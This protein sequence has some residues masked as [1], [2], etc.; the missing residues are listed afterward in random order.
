MTDAREELQAALGVTYAIDR[1]LGGGGMSRAFI[2]TER[3]LGRQVVIKVLP[4]DTAGAVSVERFKREIAFAARL[5]QANIVPLLSAGEMGGVPYFTMPYIAGQSLRARLAAEGPL[6]IADAIVI[7]TEVARALAYAH[8]A[9]VVHRDIKPDT[10]L[11]SAGTAMVTDFGVAKAISTTTTA[12]GADL[13]GTGVALGT[14]AYMSPEQAS[15]DPLADH[16]AR[17]VRS[18]RFATSRASR[19]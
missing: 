2:A 13:T 17:G 6:P 11:L 7:L 8:K 19:R 10:V 1:E 14:L 5:Q 12:T 18:T 15:G 3:A 9:G 4:T 16:R